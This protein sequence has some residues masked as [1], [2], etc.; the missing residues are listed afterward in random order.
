V[1]SDII[2]QLLIRY[3]AFFR[4]WRKNGTLHQ[5]F[6]G[7]KKMYDSEEIYCTTFSLKLQ[8]C[9]NKT[10]NKINVGEHL[11]DAFPFQNGLYQGDAL[12]PLLYSFALECTGKI[13]IECKTS[14]SG[15][16]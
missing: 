3:S 7:F 4:Y 1:D 14:A 8:M 12:L 6:V 9:L 16:F 10:C 15:L 13:G 2:D 11:A 5:L